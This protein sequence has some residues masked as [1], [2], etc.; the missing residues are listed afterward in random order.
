MQKKV[1]KQISR[2]ISLYES[3]IY[4]VR[5]KQN[6]VCTK[7]GGLCSVIFSHEVSGRTDIEHNVLSL[8][9]SLI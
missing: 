8:L 5:A 6:N 1:E 2:I 3:I 7:I 9:P 4:A